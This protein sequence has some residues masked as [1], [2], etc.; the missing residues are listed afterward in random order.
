MALD[1]NGTVI[2]ESTGSVNFNGATIDKVFLDGVQLW[3]KSVSLNW[4]GSSTASFVSGNTSTNTTRSLEASSSLIRLRHQ[5]TSGSYIS[6]N[7]ITGYF[8][9]SSVAGI[10]SLLTSN[11]LIRINRSGG[12]SATWITY[13]LSTK[14]FSGSSSSVYTGMKLP[15]DP[16]TIFASGSK[17]ETSG[18]ALRLTNY[19]EGSGDGYMDNQNTYSGNYITLY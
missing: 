4:S 6:S 17:L 3:A 9:G 14:A 8:S 1:F 18:G 13:T 7:G 10:Y 15:N 16:R 11:N 19:G 5:G 2:S 12:N